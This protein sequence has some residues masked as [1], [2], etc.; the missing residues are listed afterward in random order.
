MRRSTELAANEIIYKKYVNIGVAVDTDRGLLVPVIRDADST[1]LTQISIELSQLSEKARSRKIALDEMQGGCFSVS[2]LGGIGGGFFTPI[3]NVP[4]VAILGISRGDLRAG[5]R[6]GHR[7]VRGPRSDC[8]CRSPTI[9]ASSTA[10]TGSASC[11]GSSKRSSSH[12]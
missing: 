3:V 11:A 1:N 6:Q 7:S 5:L 12:S 8:R 10:R 2:N 9:I 4:E